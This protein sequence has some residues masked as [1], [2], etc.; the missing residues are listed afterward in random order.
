MSLPP[1]DSR[2]LAGRSFACLPGCGFCC[3]FQPEVSPEEAR[4]LRERVSPLKTIR[5]PEGRSY[6]ALQNAC[7]ACSLLQRR[8]CTQYDL[9]PAHCRYFPFHVYF[10]ESVEAY[11]NHT[12]RGL[13][14]APSHLGQAFES[15]VL[16]NAPPGKIEREAA[17]ARE[18]FAQFRVRA[19]AEGAWEDPAPLV[20]ATRARSASLFTRAGLEAEAARTG[21]RAGAEDV[22]ALALEPFEG[23][24]PAKRPFYLDR[25]LRWLSF[26]KR[27]R[28]A[29]AVAEM[30][31]T[32]DFRGASVDA[33]GGLSR[34][35]DAP[36]ALA[37]ALG[38][39]LADRLLSR[40]LFVGGAFDR[41]DELE[42][43]GTVAEAIAARACEHAAA[44]AVRARVVAA[45]EPSVA[46]DARALA[47]EAW[48][49]YDAEF[50][51]QP[52]IGGFL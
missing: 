41:V 42:Y 20:A 50:L 26:S 25:A 14:L 3:T 43:E 7:G 13:A 32:G 40:A 30:T 34:W 49:F 22:L 38:E 11:A 45:V 5:G 24:D 28:D 31:E 21:E 8:E 35:Q 44:L 10:G 17:S 52:T 37:S 18:V 15:S 39:V 23:P 47:E 9:R 51:D 27:G 48:R 19:E 29:L 2:D 6:L 36:P 46:L 4:R 16:A 1:I 33:I 12:C